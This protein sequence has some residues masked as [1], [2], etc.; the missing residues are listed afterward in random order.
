MV[1]VQSTTAIR[2]KIHLKSR[3]AR[4]VRPYLF[5]D[6]QTSQTE[7][8]KNKISSEESPRKAVVL[9]TLLSVLYKQLN[10]KTFPHSPFSYL[11]KNSYLC[12]NNTE[13]TKI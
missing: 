10:S 1:R 12:S 11:P 9:S 6:H 8:Q 13:Y 5:S 3:D 4:F 2:Y 7:D